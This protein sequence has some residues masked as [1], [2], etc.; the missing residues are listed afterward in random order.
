M[1]TISPGQAL[2]IIIDEVQKQ[3][4]LMKKPQT[5]TAKDV[6]STH[7]ADDIH[8][9]EVFLEKCKVNYLS[10][11][12]KNGQ[13]IEPDEIHDL[14]RKGQKYLINFNVSFEP[15][16]I[17]ED[18]SRRYFE[19]HLAYETIKENIDQLDLAKLK[20]HYE[21]LMVFLPSNIQNS[22]NEFLT[23]KRRPADQWIEIMDALKKINAAD[24][25]LKLLP[26]KSKKH[27]DIHETFSLKNKEKMELL[28]KILPITALLSQKTECLP[29]KIYGT[30]YYHEDNRGRRE[31]DTAQDTVFS[32]YLG[33]VKS[34]MPIPNFDIA[35][36]P[37]KATS[38]RIT[39]R[40]DFDTKAIWL[41]KHFSEFRHPFSASI[42]GIMLLQMRSVAF[43]HAQKK[44]L[45]NTA[46]EL[47]AYLRLFTSLFLYNSGGHSFYEFFA[48]LEL[49]AIEQ[50]LNFIKDFNTINMT[51]LFYEQNQKAFDS[52]LKRTIEYNNHLLNKRKLNEE[53]PGTVAV[54]TQIKEIALF[55]KEYIDL[56]NDCK[57]SRSDPAKQ[58]FTETLLE[59][60][61]KEYV[62]ICD[63]KKSSIEKLNA[64]MQIYR[65]L[66]EARKNDT[67]KEGFF[68]KSYKIIDDKDFTKKRS[69]GALSVRHVI[70]KYATH[71]AK[72]LK[73]LLD[74]ALA[75]Q[76]MIEKSNT[77]ATTAV[78]PPKK[79]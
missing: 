27:F 2:L 53:I 12:Y 32:Q 45:Y 36:D 42:S 24:Y 15:K 13:R 51:H 23:G 57:K 1:L 34:Y 48:V 26:K 19:T 59:G 7:T 25:Y 67:F 18:A 62:I 56:I 76:E 8:R 17:N 50:G 4:A 21:T 31:K 29:L 44:L 54:K 35:K 43:L 30:G 75:Q 14:I 52:S 28:I 71:D 55:A 33:L 40:F 9:L 65:L 68:S 41:Q 74:T 6:K 37:K 46:E 47:G 70:A 5:N 60:L 66:E 10:R 64:A 20:K 11:P 58:T 49:D 72:I 73:R 78:A 22:L 79:I 16:I 39:D 38:L 61:K 69:E 77:A 3:L 63:N